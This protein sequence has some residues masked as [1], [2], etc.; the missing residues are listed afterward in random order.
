M[1]A[2]YLTRFVKA[3]MAHGNEKTSNNTQ[4]LG[5]C[6]G[7]TGALLK[8]SQANHVRRLDRGSN[9]QVWIC[10]SLTLELKGSSVVK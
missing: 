2:L 10:G 5:G 6:R 9:A 3:D 1:N 7:G 8:K 4:I